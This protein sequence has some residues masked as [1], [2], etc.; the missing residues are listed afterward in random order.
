MKKT[1]VLDLDETLVH[2]FTGNNLEYQK[3]LRIPQTGGKILEVSNSS[4]LDKLSKFSTIESEKP[5]IRLRG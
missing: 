1:L 3:V 4:K 5:S 2:C